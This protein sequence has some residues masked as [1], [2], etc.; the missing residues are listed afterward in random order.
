MP[1]TGAHTI[2]PLT[3]SPLLLQKVWGGD[4][5]AR[6][7][8]AVAPGDTIG[9]SWELADLASTSASGAGG[10]AAESVI[11]A[12]PLAGK[13]LHDAVKLWGADL[14]GSAS[15]PDTRHPIPD[16]R[17][18]LLVKYLDARENLSVQVHPSIAYARAHPGAH[19][20]TECWYILDAAPGAVIYKGVK[21]GVTRASFEKHLR[22]GD[23]A[24]VLND[25]EA[26]PA[27]VGDMH[28]LPSGTVHALG[29]GVVVAEVQTP[30]DTTFR[31]YDWGRVGRE[32]HVEQALECITFAPARDATRRPDAASHA[33]LV[34]T[35]FFTVDELRVGAHPSEL[36]GAETPARP[37][38][39]LSLHGSSRIEHTA[40]AY[41]PLDVPAGT[42][43]LIPAS[44]AH[45]S[46]VSGNATAL[47]VEVL[48]AFE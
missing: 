22:T 43:V 16:T 18:P 44:L 14:L 33:R 5:L 47:R 9:E 11:A 46:R 48:S 40:G 34:T 17:F 27:R 42:T 19:I 23:G 26:V 20:K 25:L 29:A 36:L 35:G 38:V 4:R 6:F 15:P 39:L 1:D 37:V 28:N 21:P 13:T 2:L 41:P 3:F 10:G 24:G 12:G 8:K 45:S 7:G 32:L 31:V 30:S